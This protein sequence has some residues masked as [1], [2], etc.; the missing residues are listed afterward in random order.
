MRSTPPFRA[1]HVGSFLRPPDLIAARSSYEQGRISAAERRQR[2][3]RAIRDVVKMQE[4]LGF[5][6][7]TDGELRRAAFHSDFLYEIE[8]VSHRR[9]KAHWHNQ[10]G[11]IEL[12]PNAVWIEGKLRLDKCIF[13]EDFRFLKS[14]AHGTP[15]LTIPAPSLLHYRGGRALIDPRM[16]PDLEDFWAD[17]SQVYA[18]EIA[19]LGRIGCSYLQLDDT[20]LAYLNDPEQRRYVT[21]LGSDG[22][23]LHRTYIRVMNAA[24]KARPA[25]M[26][27]CTHLC[28]GN[29]K[30][31][32]VASGGY[33]FVADA[34]F[35]EL[36]VDG[37]FLEY[38]DP[39]SGD[40]TP[41]RFLPKGKI[42]VLG[43][44][45][46]KSG[47]LETKEGLKRRLDEASK[48]VPLDQICLSPQC[49]FAS[50]IEGNTLTV[51][52]QIAK[53]RLVVETADDVW[54]GAKA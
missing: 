46:S 40:F 33:D 7:I 8:G 25:G 42:V 52:E 48:F 47:T 23:N 12:A 29:F 50:T 10:H 27:V 37:F 39:R 1:D 45:T 21:G 41:L 4:G 19:A 2:E 20:S 30:S 6:G 51:E 18:Y 43:L 31:S 38:D 17:V 5:R 32:W 34:L 14:I 35:N 54:C 44:V 22:S 53:L 24:L 26:T 28:R 49:G 16:Y 9:V 15:K 11:D 13:E 36:Q 3:D